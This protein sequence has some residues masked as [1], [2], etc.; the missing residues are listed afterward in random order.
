MTIESNRE[1]VYVGKNLT[2]AEA[3]KIAMNHRWKH[4]HRGFKYDKKTGY[5]T[6]I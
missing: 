1:R 4:D 2:K 6:A 3:W 5:V